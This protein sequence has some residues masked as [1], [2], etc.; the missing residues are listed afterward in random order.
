M[1]TSF[2]DLRAVIGRLQLLRNL[3]P[4]WIEKF[5]PQGN[6][7]QAIDEFLQVARQLLLGAEEEALL[8]ENGY[9][10]RLMGL[11]SKRGPDFFRDLIEEGLFP[12][13]I[14]RRAS[15]DLPM[16][17][18]NFLNEFLPGKLILISFEPFSGLSQNFAFKSSES[19]RKLVFRLA[20]HV[21]FHVGQ[22]PDTTA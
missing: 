13:R 8:P 9:P 18:Q 12:L 3:D 21:G 1:D 10:K 14:F 6:D 15:M 20:G 5:L 22:Q 19:L 2:Q 4:L 11:F 17:A 7:Q 16:S